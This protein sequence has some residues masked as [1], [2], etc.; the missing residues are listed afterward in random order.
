LKAAGTQTVRHTLDD[1]D[2]ADRP[3]L[4]RVRDVVVLRAGTTACVTR[5][6]VVNRLPVGVFDQFT[7]ARL[8]Q[9]GAGRRG[10]RRPAPGGRCARPQR[11]AMADGGLDEPAPRRQTQRPPWHVYRFTFHSVV[12]VATTEPYGATPLTLPA[13]AAMACWMTPSTTG[14]PCASRL[15]ILT[16]S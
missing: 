5:Y 7:F 9:A 6:G 12:G 4:Q 11:N 3:R 13:L 16:I 8:A 2:D 15:G 10:A 1:D 14:C